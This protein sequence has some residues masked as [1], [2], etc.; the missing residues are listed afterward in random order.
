MGWV[1][2][3]ASVSENISEY[4]LIA[5]ICVVLYFYF[6]RK[7]F[8]DIFDPF[9][10]S[11]FNFSMASSVVCYMF[12]HDML[13]DTALF[14]NFVFTEIAY[15]GGFILFKPISFKV[16]GRL[17]SSLLFLKDRF[18]VIIY[19]IYTVIYL[20]NQLVVYVLYG[21]PIFSEST[22]A[23]FYQDA[24]MSQAIAIAVLPVII[25]LLIDR[26]FADQCRT[27][28]S[29]VY[30]V[31]MLLFIFFA[32]AV[33]GSKGTL[34]T[35]VYSLFFYKLY[36]NTFQQAP[37]ILMNLK[38]I[39]TMYKIFFLLAISGAILTAIFK[40]NAGE[41]VSV[42]EAVLGIMVRVVATG[43]VFAHFYGNDPSSLISAE[44][45]FYNLFMELFSS[46]VGK[47]GLIDSNDVKMPIG[48][49]YWRIMGIPPGAGTGPNPR[50][51]FFGLVLFGFYGNIIY[52]FLLGLVSGFVRNKLY[53]KLR[54]N[55]FYFILY[56]QLYSLVLGFTT[57]MILL[58][59]YLYKFIIIN[60]LIIGCV[61]LV[62]KYVRTPMESS[63]NQI[64]I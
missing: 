12:I 24:K 62:L 48:D 41:N 32:L 39:K 20:L 17:D 34:L 33:S 14:Y 1:S 49:V 51:N 40:D 45:G 19:Y 46:I 61:Y 56:T 64:G 55:I 22:H 3:L 10:M 59:N 7:Y 11:I 44:N 36:L 28:F 29:K 52:S 27:V 13:G 23:G 18:K 31:F 9:T 43:D 42:D 16:Q 37:S 35:F 8:L 30:D 53:S 5:T 60:V 26:F 38:K 54:S 63:N 6:F 4:I 50:H 58:F 21:L 15:I 47:L 2:F 25:F 57:D